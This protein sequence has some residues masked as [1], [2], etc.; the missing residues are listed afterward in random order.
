M[1]ASKPK[2]W[3]A[4]TDKAEG[5]WEAPG[6]S[7]R[8]K[9]TLDSGHPFTWFPTHIRVHLLPKAFSLA[10]PPEIS[11]PLLW[12]SR[13]QTPLSPHSPTDKSSLHGFSGLAPASSSSQAEI[14]ADAPGNITNDPG[15]GV[16]GPGGISKA[17]LFIL[18]GLPT[19]NMSITQELARNAN[20]G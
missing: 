19:S 17:W 4:T 11:P 2:L 9:I 7:P 1:R 20:L 6:P 18:C 5:W 14:P 15:Y 3:V 8:L 16:P 10:M 13:N 12:C